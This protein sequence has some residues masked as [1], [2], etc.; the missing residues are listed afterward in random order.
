[1]SK[2]Q[3]HRM[4]GENFEQ[5]A[6]ALLEKNRRGFGVLT[7]FGL[8]A[9][10][11]REAT[12][13]Q[14]TDHPTYIRPL[15]ATSDVAKR[16]V[17][18]VKFH[19]IGLRGW[20]GAGAAVVSDLRSELEK[21]TT[22]HDVPCHHYV[23][24]TNVPLSG[25]RRIGTRDQITR[26]AEEWQKK[27]PNIEVW[28]AVDL[29]RMLDNNS[30]VR[31]AYDELILPG[32]VIAAIY[33]QVQFQADRREN[34][35][36]GY[37]L[38]L[39]A[40]ESKARADEAGDEDPLPLSKVFVDQILRLDKERIPE[41]YREI[42]ES[43]VSTTHRD[44]DKNSITPR[45]LD[46]VSSSFP[47][48]LAAHDKIMLLAG[49]GYGKSTI[50]Q[51]LALFHACRIVKPDYATDLANR[52]KLPPGV[53]P[54][55]LDAF[56]E[57]RF[58]FRVELRHY[59][60]WR[61]AASDDKEKIGLATY[62]VRELVGKNVASNLVE[63][64]IFELA[65]R[66]PI[67][68]ILDGLDE[69]PN[70]ESRDEIL[71]DCD[72]FIFRCS[73]ENAD[74]QIVMS[75]RPQGYNGEFDRFEPIR[76]RIN[77]LSEKDFNSYCHAW[78]QE[79]IKNADERMEAEDRIRRGMESEAV[80][81]LATT[82]LQATVMLTIVRRKSDIPGERHKLFAKYVDVVFEREKT[83]IELISLYERELRRLHETV[84]YRLHIT[85]SGSYSISQGRGQVFTLAVDRAH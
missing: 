9:D 81:R 27:I 63:D 74:L 10:G 19:E 2:Y 48:L 62:I 42:V 26:V 33:R 49:P 50:T 67:L 52:L 76:W 11:S 60:K 68:L 54:D 28:D 13:L 59:A 55:T 44:S 78:L 58:P 70:K 23:L 51:F 80:K 22:K 37:L 43:W 3:F 34:T 79:R 38:Y 21:L 20:A 12:W 31:A 18:Q 5:M 7:Q 65:S 15:G 1:M 82:L 84:G 4:G 36:R 73:G 77:D 57:M 39:V 45:D 8:G 83:K 25:A 41:S 24:I 29:S 40:N 6:Q 32:D 75:S 64:D 71:K 53:S 35:F 61:R 56:C 69:V 14:P 30:D 46:A 47:L 85:R 16:W 17:F 66:N 72:A